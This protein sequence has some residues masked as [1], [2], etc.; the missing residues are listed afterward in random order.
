MSASKRPTRKPILRK[1]MARLAVMVDLPTPPL[2]EATAMIFLI[3]SIGLPLISFLSDA[4]AAS[5]VIL[6]FTFAFS[7]TSAWIA[8]MI[9]TSTFFFACREGLE[10]VA[11]TTTSSPKITIFFTTPASIRLPP[12][13]GE[14]IL[15]RAS[16]T[17]DFNKVIIVLNFEFWVANN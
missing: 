12:S 2:P 11:S 8:F 13:P 15:R 17:W 16:I 4:G 7:Y 3:P 1:A 10:I 14:V 6:T 9:S 5:T